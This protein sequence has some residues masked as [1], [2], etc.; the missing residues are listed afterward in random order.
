MLQRTEAGTCSSGR[1][2]FLQN[3]CRRHRAAARSRRRLSCRAATV[4]HTTLKRTSLAVAQH[5]LERRCESTVAAAYAN[6][7]ARVARALGN[8]QRAQVGA[9]I[10]C[11]SRGRQTAVNSWPTSAFHAFFVRAR[12]HLRTCERA[13]EPPRACDSADH[14]RARKLVSDSRRAFGTNRALLSGCSRADADR[15]QPSFCIRINSL[16]NA[17]DL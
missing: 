10:D 14:S 2:R 3:F 13:H 8:C 15:L 16:A 6:A 1:L 12:P 7:S 11:E 9:M 17:D 5:T 4:G